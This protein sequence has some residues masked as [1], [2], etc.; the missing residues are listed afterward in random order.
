[1]NKV[2]QQIN[3]RYKE[4]EYSKR[5]EK[6]FIEGELV[7]AHLQKDRFPRATYNKLKYKK[8]GPCRIL[9]KKI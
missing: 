1:V 3:D 4:K 8:I 9:Q 5:R 2:L 7:M 6:V